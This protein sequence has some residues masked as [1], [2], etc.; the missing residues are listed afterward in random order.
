MT[1]SKGFR[2]SNNSLFEVTQ[3]AIQDEEKKSLRLRNFFSYD[4]TTKKIALNW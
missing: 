4:Y 3:L 1:R 2:V